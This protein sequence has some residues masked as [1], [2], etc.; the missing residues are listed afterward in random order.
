MLLPSQH[1]PVQSELCPAESGN[2]PAQAWTAQPRVWTE[3]DQHSTQGEHPADVPA[4]Q[5][6]HFG[7]PLSFVHHAE[8]L[9]ARSIG[10]DADVDS[11]PV[12]AIPPATNEPIRAACNESVQWIHQMSS[13]DPMA[14]VRDRP[15]PRP[16]DHDHQGTV[17]NAVRLEPR[18]RSR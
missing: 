14:S 13:V 18:A 8:R 15:D 17:R 9:Y 11:T 7:S 16:I 5:R 2:G 3:T 1:C 4:M 6:F 10:S 12:R